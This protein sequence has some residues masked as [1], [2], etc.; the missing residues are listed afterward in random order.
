MGKLSNPPS[1]KAVRNVVTASVVLTL[2]HFTDNFVS[3]DTYPAAGWQ[4]DWF[5]SSSSSA[6]CCSPRSA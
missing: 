6:G 1:T 5:E 4:P 2:F 3:I